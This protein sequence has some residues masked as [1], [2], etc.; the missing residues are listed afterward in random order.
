MSAVSGIRND[1]RADGL[2]KTA[3]MFVLPKLFMTICRRK[4]VGAF[5]REPRPPVAADAAV[6]SDAI[7][8]R[9]N[10]GGVTI[11]R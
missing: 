10:S 4:Y 6:N 5:I 8:V 2:G 7:G 1:E 11:L 9:E 3:A